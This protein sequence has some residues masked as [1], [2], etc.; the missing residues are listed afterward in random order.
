MNRL[1]PLTRSLNRTPLVMLVTLCPIALAACEVDQ[2]KE[3][4]VY[5]EVID[6][7][8]P[9]KLREFADDSSLSLAEALVMA[10]RENERLSLTG[11]NYLQAVIEKKRVLANFLPT[12]SLAP[13]FT[14]VDVANSA[15]SPDEYIDLPFRTGYANFNAPRD[16]AKFDSS[17]FTIEERRALLL[18]AKESL[19]I[20]TAQAY[21]EV[22]RAERQFAVL[23]NSLAVQEERVRD[24]SAQQEAGVARPLD[25]AQAKSQAASTRTLLE[26]ARGDIRNARAALAFLIGAKRVEG[27]LEDG[28]DP[29]EQTP[30]LDALENAAFEHRKDLAAAVAGVHAARHSVDAAIAQYYPS[31]TLNLD[32]F[33]YRESIPTESI[34][35][36]MLSANIP[37]FTAG[38]I[39]ADVRTAW[40]QFRQ[41]K[42]RE[43]FVRRQIRRDVAVAHAALETS[44]RRIKDLVTEVAAAREAFDQAADLVRFGRATNLERLVAQD[45]LLSAQLRQ[46]NEDYTHKVASLSL[47]RATGDLTVAAGAAPAATQPSR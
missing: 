14:K 26:Q 39:H 47:R 32:T 2:T 3:I 8:L 37:V 18:D 29:S 42:L 5:R 24:V 15:F 30:S 36:A 22:L 20:D 25:V 45:E 34:Y 11:E 27:K 1:T 16:I 44:E 17:K 12:V 7:D 33:V 38:R 21:Y 4:G 13:A 19:L 46:A 6:A 9:P 41:A 10:A 35:T 40:S 28:F 23:T 31:V 43:S